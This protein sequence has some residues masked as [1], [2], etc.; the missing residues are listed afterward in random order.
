[1][2]KTSMTLDFNLNSEK[3]KNLVTSSKIPRFIKKNQV[4]K[5]ISHEVHEVYTPLPRKMTMAT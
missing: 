2:L 5:Q 1:M 4:K 3:Q